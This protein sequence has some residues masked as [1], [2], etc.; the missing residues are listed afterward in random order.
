ML[1][2]ELGLEHPQQPMELVMLGGAIA[3]ASTANSPQQPTGA[4]SHLDATKARTFGMLVCK[5][6][7]LRVKGATMH[8]ADDPRRL[9]LLC[10]SAA[11]ACICGQVPEI[12]ETVDSHFGLDDI[13]SLE[14][15]QYF[16]AGCVIAT[17]QSV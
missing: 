10:A 6:A 12:L 7:L 15:L 2:Q 9:V 5:G 17:L 13:W 14:L 8:P 1:S 4:G 11:T 16:S 3:I